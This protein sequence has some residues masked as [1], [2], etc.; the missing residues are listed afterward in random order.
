MTL[1]MLHDYFPAKMQ[2]VLAKYPDGTYVLE[3]PMGTPRINFGKDIEKLTE[4]L[5]GEENNFNK[6]III[7]YD[8]S[9]PKKYIRLLND[10]KMIYEL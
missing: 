1:E 6:Y 7:S 3:T 4:Y 9:M 5:Y 2:V 10:M 8:E